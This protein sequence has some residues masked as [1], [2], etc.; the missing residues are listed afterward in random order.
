MDF[1]YIDPPMPSFSRY[2]AMMQR[3][4]GAS[5]LRALEYEAV[6][7]LPLKGRVLDFGGG[8]R[9]KY[10]PLLPAGLDLAS[11][12]IDEEFQ[13]TE[14][15]PVGAPL[16][17]E[18]DSFDGAISL[19]VFEHIYD[20]RFVLDEIFR[21]LK[22]GG[23]LYAAVPWMFR[24]HGHP[25]D[26]SRHTA[27]WWQKTIELT[28]FSAMTIQPMCWGKATSGRMIGGNGMLGS[29]N[30][31]AAVLTDIVTARARSKSRTH[32]VGKAA[33]RAAAVAPGWLFTA[34]K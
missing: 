32:M 16:P 4:P 9:A 10:V 28:G 13:P 2:R 34:T 8:Q 31:W 22:P 30:R 7:S 27:S 5:M 11:V 25:D 21:V 24:V 6:V 29:V 18:A 3:A 12:N 26:Y 14:I 33:T 15:V 23:T 20:T 19:N 17:F 1:Q